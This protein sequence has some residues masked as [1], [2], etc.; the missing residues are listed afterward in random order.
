MSD[1]STGT[2]GVL[3]AVR[4]QRT[5]VDKAAR[6]GL[7]GHRPMVVWFT[8]LSGAG[9]STIANL[10]EQKLHE[11]GTRTYLLDGD[12]LRH[13]LN[14]DLGFSSTERHENV[15]RVAEVAALMVDAGLV[16]LVSLISPFKAERE[17][18]R[19]LVAEGE[20]HNAWN[21]RWLAWP[22]RGEVSPGQHAA[23]HERWFG[24][25]RPH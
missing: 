13:G 1:V 3:P 20:F 7:S 2:G 11:Q 15:R 21:L 5:T 24:A 23:G 19:S 17:L 16:V 6:A 4:W 10:L 12:N 14:R 22:F 8:G 25:V 18:A 9:K